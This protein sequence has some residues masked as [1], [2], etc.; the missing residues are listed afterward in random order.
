MVGSTVAMHAGGSMRVSSSRAATAAALVAGLAVLVVAGWLLPTTPSLQR[1]AT[2]ISPGA[3]AGTVRIIPLRDVPTST[4][5]GGVR[6]PNAIGHT[7]ARATSLMRTVGLHGVAFERDPQI[8]TAVVVSQEPPA[9]V[10]IPRGD[11]VGFR[12]RTDVQANGSPRRLRLGRGPT[13][14]GYQVVAPDPA[15]QRLT[16]VV[17][18]P[19]AVKLQVWLATVSGRRVPILDTSSGAAPLPPHRRTVPLRGRDRRAGRRGLRGVDRNHRQ[20]IVRASGGPGHGHLRAP[21]TPPRRPSDLEARGEELPAGSR[22]RR[23]SGRKVPCNDPSVVPTGRAGSPHGSEAG[24]RLPGSP[25]RWW[26]RAVL[27]MGWWWW[28]SWYWR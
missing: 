16:V 3:P 23:R 25:A 9:G 19:P 20:A 6:V 5:V 28:A 11:V 2:S 7:L 12:T 15:R 8:S 24:R 1:P 14:W 17:A 18:M 10:L 21:L 4:V 27:P 26:T 13:I 22:T